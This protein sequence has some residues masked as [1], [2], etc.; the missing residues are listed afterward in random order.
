[1]KKKTFLVH[2]AE[3]DIPLNSGLRRAP[4]GLKDTIRIIEY[5]DDNITRD[6][7][8]DVLNGIPLFNQTSLSSLRDLIKC[9]EIE[10]FHAD[11]YVLQIL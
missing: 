10:K 3:K 9:A 4:S 8:L 1:V 11:D 6:D 7:I 5:A 2:V